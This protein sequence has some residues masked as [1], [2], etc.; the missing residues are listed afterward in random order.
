MLRLTLTR[1]IPISIGATY[2]QYTL[3]RA[4]A[5]TQQKQHVHSYRLNLIFIESGLH[6]KHLR[7]HHP[8]HPVDEPKKDSYQHTFS[9]PFVT[10][11]NIID[12]QKF[13]NL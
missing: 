8:R 1:G 6:A 10:R 9:S 4:R 11:Y 13:A 2:T 5:L 7:R 12:M 3:T